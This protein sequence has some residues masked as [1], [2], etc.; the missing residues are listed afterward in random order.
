MRISIQ[1]SALVDIK[2]GFQFYE[3]KEQGLG[4]YFLDSLYSDI[5]SLL[6]YAGI[7]SKHFG[8]YRILSSRFPYAVYYELGDNVV[9]IRAAL[10]L[11]RD[12][13]WIARKLTKLK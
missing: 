3:E 10:D 1:P 4:N 6:L 2:A 7:H 11:R 12:P 9:F 13:A 5:D 8:K